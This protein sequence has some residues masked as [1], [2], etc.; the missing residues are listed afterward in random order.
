MEQSPGSPVSQC[1]L[2]CPAVPPSPL[3]CDTG[4]HL[5]T[6]LLKARSTAQVHS[7]LGF[8]DIPL[9]CHQP[10]LQGGR[11]GAKQMVSLLLLPLQSEGFF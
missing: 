8:L 7:A 3:P 9:G 10:I 11:A 4:L 2:A 1:L 5:E 6:V